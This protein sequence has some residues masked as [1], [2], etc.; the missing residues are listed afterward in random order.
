MSK[1]T[2]KNK[3]ALIIIAVAVICAVLAAGIRYYTETHKNAK[4]APKATSAEMTAEKAPADAPKV[5]VYMAET[6]PTGIKLAPTEVAV[7]PSSEDEPKADFAL[8]VLLKSGKAGESEALIPK[9][10]E[11]ISPISVKGDVAYVDFNEAISD[12]FS[13]GSEMEALTINAIAHT[14]VKNSNPN[15]KKVKIL[16]EGRD[17]ETIGGHFELFDPVEPVNTLLA[18]DTDKP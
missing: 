14:V 18:D 4:P 11:L 3:S 5:I 7:P 8:K 12:N 16:I 6:T 9:D 2:K 17:A 10:T 1:K 15:V 13:G